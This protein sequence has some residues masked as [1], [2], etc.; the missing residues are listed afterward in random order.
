MYAERSLNIAGARAGITVSGR[1]VFDYPGYGKG[2]YQAESGASGGGEFQHHRSNYNPTYVANAVPT[3]NGY[4]SV[5]YA[6]L[7]LPTLDGTGSFHHV[8]G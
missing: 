7:A 6:G 5:G 2:Y 3:E 8:S 1:R 4:A